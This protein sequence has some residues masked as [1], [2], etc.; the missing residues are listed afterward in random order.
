MFCLLWDL[1]F[2]QCQSVDLDEYI[3]IQDGPIIEHIFYDFIDL[4]LS[5]GSCKLREFGT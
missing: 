3:G 1:V 2:D 4:L 5:E